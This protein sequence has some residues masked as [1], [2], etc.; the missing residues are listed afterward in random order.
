MIGE[1]WN[2]PEFELSLL[3]KGKY[4]SSEDFVRGTPTKI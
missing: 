2:E 4:A 1:E 3:S